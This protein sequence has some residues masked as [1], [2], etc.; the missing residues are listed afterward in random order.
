MDEI[1]IPLASMGSNSAMAV[2]KSV[3]IFLRR[4][5]KSNEGGAYPRADAALQSGAYR[6]AVRRNMDLLIC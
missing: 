5:N 1:A 6:E 2:L 3:R 4:F